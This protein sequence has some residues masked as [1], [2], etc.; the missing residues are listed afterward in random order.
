MTDQ[1]K[2]LITQLLTGIGMYFVGRGW[3]TT[4]LLTGTIIP[5]AVTAIGFGYSIYLA[6]RGAKVAAVATPGTM[7]VLPTS[8]A[9]LAASLPSNVATT[10]EVAVVAK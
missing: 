2:N 8:E 3:I 1:I 4:D 9:S 5:F 7:I 10:A 6:T